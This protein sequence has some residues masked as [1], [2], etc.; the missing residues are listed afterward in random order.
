MPKQ[1][2][3][4]KAESNDEGGPTEALNQS[5]KGNREASVQSADNQAVLA[6]IASLQAELSQAKSDICDKIDEKIADVST[7][8]RGE[9]AALKT[10]SDTAFFAVNAR[11]D[12]QNETLESLGE[13]ANVTSD[14]VV[15]LEARVKQLHSQVEQLSAK[16]L[17]LEG[18]S[19]RQNLRIAGV[20][21]GEE[22]G[23]KTR[24]FVAQLL[25]DVLKLD[26]KPVIDRAHRALRERPSGNGP[27]RHLILRVHYC[28]ALEDILQKVMKTKRLIYQGQQIQVFRDFPSE[29]VKRR[30]AFTPARNLLR[31]QPGVK[32]GLLYPA[33]LRVTHNGNE[34]TFTDPK[35]A[36]LY[37]ERHFGQ[38]HK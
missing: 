1:R 36:R 21:E 35:E 23:Q 3:Q 24:D 4:S 20:K 27:P 19:K 2:G 10:E 9:M 28:H 32:F 34:T 7:T 29:V 30:A 31:D 5:G 18:R 37:A 17:D 26:E 38:G 11:L 12:T 25:M 15:E 33:K 13:S 6:A 22:N 14:T 8:L 16:C